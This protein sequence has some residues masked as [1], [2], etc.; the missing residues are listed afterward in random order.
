[1]FAFDSG[2][3]R[4]PQRGKVSPKVTD[5]V[6]VLR[7]GKLPW[8][9]RQIN[10]VQILIYSSSTASGPPSPTGE[11]KCTRNCIRTKRFS[12]RIVGMDCFFIL[13]SEVSLVLSFQR[14][15][16][17]KAG[18]ALQASHHN[19][20]GTNRRF[21]GRKPRKR[22]VIPF[23]MAFDSRHPIL[24]SRMAMEESRCQ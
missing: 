12:A 17:Q 19:R 24:P 16:Q 2:Y 11:G 6:L 23:S 4:L 21:C 5:E 8:R 13:L 10:S 22:D 3:I 7:F 1:M 15:N 18:R 14:K 9:K 20:G